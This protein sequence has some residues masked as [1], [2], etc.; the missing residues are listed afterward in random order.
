MSPTRTHSI[1]KWFGQYQKPAGANTPP[2]ANRLRSKIGNKKREHSILP[3][4]ACHGPFELRF[5]FQGLS[6]VLLPRRKPRKAVTIALPWSNV[7][8]CST[9][10]TYIQSKMLIYRSRVTLLPRKLLLPVWSKGE[11]DERRAA[12]AAEFCNPFH[13][14]TG[15]SFSP[16]LRNTARAQKIAPR[17]LRVMTTVVRKIIDG[18]SS[19]Q[20]IDISAF[21][22]YSSGSRP[23][24]ARNLGSYRYLR[25]GYYS[26][27]INLYRRK[28]RHFG[29]NQ[30]R[31]NTSGSFTRSRPTTT[32]GTL[33]SSASSAPSSPLSPANPLLSLCPPLAGARPTPSR[34]PVACRTRSTMRI[35]CPHTIYCGIC[36][37]AFSV[38]V[39]LTGCHN[40]P[41][42]IYSICGLFVTAPHVFVDTALRPGPSK[43][44]GHKNQEQVKTLS[45]VCQINVPNTRADYS[46]RGPPIPRSMNQAS[47]VCLRS[48][49]RGVFGSA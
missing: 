43:I 25:P 47:F 10:D 5:F 32:F 42:V 31:N 8:F 41:P 2:L 45:K 40:E 18:S 3:T 35:P 44:L 21:K 7:G 48:T 22:A 16:F 26:R 20:N 36:V 4:I 1:T 19:G 9:A 23:L 6:S 13:V 29:C 38:S 24:G 28:C 27:A 12:A 34:T 17:T 30:G 46:P 14:G 37:K 49:R 15:V 33:R 11:C 39:Q